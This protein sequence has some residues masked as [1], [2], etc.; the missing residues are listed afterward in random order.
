MKD[1][2]TFLNLKKAANNCEGRKEKVK[3]AMKSYDHNVLISQQVG[4][5]NKD[6]LYQGV[7]DEPNQQVDVDL[8][9][10]LC[11]VLQSIETDRFYKVNKK[12]IKESDKQFRKR[13]HESETTCM[14][15]IDEEYK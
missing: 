3:R 7:T 1:V 15:L 12:G 6:I 11:V 2:K 8:E 5:T 4:R 9:R 13:L 10:R 14:D